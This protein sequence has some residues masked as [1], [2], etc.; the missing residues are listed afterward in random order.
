MMKASEIALWSCD[1]Q[2]MSAQHTNK[3]QSKRESLPPQ[4]V[5]LAPP[6]VLK[7]RDDQETGSATAVKIE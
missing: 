5:E 6:E 3:S 4:L 1:L 2:I 7:I